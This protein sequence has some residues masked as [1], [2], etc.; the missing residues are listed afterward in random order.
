MLAGRLRLEYM[1]TSVISAGSEK[2][3]TIVSKFKSPGARY[4]GFSKNIKKPKATGMIRQPPA[5]NLSLGF[6]HFKQEFVCF[7]RINDR[8]HLQLLPAQ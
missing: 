1:E 4:R 3:E 8:Q 2:Q 6:K 5:E 7:L